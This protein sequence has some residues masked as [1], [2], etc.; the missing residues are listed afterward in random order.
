MT[1]DQNSPS[2]A[3]TQVLYI[4]VRSITLC[5]FR[6]VEF[7]RARK[8]SFY[9][10]FHIN[11]ISPNHNNFCDIHIYYIISYV[12]QIEYNFKLII[13]KFYINIKI[14]NVHL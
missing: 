8:L 4:T 3:N 5:G 9:K 10:V 2:A 6:K 12:L 1:L 14:Y 13:E 7:G 11:S